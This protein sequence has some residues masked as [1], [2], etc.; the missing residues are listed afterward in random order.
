MVIQ[1]RLISFL[2]LTTICQVAEDPHCGF[3]TH[4]SHRVWLSS[5]E[6]DL[7]KTCLHFRLWLAQ[8]S[9]HFQR[10][11]FCM[12]RQEREGMGVVSVTSIWGGD[13][14]VGRENTYWVGAQQ[15][16]NCLPG[17]D[18]RYPPSWAFCSVRFTHLVTVQSSSWTTCSTA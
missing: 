5:S 13:G 8:H 2:S 11:S 7:W 16:A 1:H 4:C 10:P 9:F 15:L 17:E 3:L 18:G 6:V 12:D 14:E